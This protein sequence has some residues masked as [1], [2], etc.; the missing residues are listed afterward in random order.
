MAPSESSWNILLVDD[1]EG[2]RTVVRRSLEGDGHYVETADDGLQAL[3]KFK[4]AKWNLVITDRLMPKLGG[5]GLAKAIKQ[6]DPTIPVILVT[7][8]VDHA[9]DVR[10][11]QS[12][13]DI[14]IPKPFRYDTIRAAI[15]SI[16]LGKDV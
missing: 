1:D 10:G 2:I 5:D 9:P 11:D 4:A 13:F 14:V 6:I 8:S 16:Q 15:A 12:P 3:N 7:G